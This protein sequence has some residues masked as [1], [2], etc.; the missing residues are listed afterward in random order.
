MNKKL[1]IQVLLP[2]A[3]FYSFKEWQH[4]PSTNILAELLAKEG[5]TTTEVDSTD[6][7]IKHIFPQINFEQLKEQSKK[8][9]RR[10]E[11]KEKLTIDELNSYCKEKIFLELVH[12]HK[13]TFLTSTNAIN[14]QNTL[15][16]KK[17]L[18]QNIIRQFTTTKNKSLED[19]D[20]WNQKRDYFQ[21][22]I[23]AKAYEKL[24]DE[25][26]IS[27][28]I[29]VMSI[30]SV[31]HLHSG[32]VLSAQIKKRKPNTHIVFGG[33]FVNLTEEKKLEQLCKKNILNSYSKK[34]SEHNL[35]L[36]INELAKGKNIQGKIELA[37]E[38]ISINQLTT[39]KRVFQGP[40]RI[41]L[42]KGCYWGK[43]TFCD[44]AATNPYFE[45]KKKEVIIK[46]IKTLYDKGQKE[47]L[48]ITDALPAQY[49]KQ[50][51]EEL[52][53]HQLKIVWGARFLRVEKEYNQELFILMKK[54][55]FAF[56]KYL[57]NIGIDSFSKKALQLAN[58][59]YTPETIS[60]FLEEAKQA[61]ITFERLNIIYDLPGTTFSDMQNTIRL[62]EKYSKQYKTIAFFSLWIST[63]SIM[64]QKPELFGLQLTTTRQGKKVKSVGNL[65]EF[66]DLKGMNAQEKKNIHTQI[67]FFEEINNIC[68]SYPH[69]NKE[70]LLRAKRYQALQKDIKLQ[71]QPNKLTF[72]T[73]FNAKGKRLLKPQECITQD[74]STC[75]DHTILEAQSILQQLEQEKEYSLKELLNTT[76]Q[77]NKKEQVIYEEH[78][79]RT[80]KK[81]L[82][83]EYFL[84]AKN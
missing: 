20:F 2:F 80:I 45:I 7:F 74:I 21:E 1:S 35:L 75:Y 77:Q 39:T 51:A 26:L 48:L 78:Q 40:S 9:I 56:D 29:I 67:K 24:I 65:L 63:T 73:S 41:L 54:S 30:P 8:Q 16:T 83:K 57:L 17:K 58:K 50:I 12:H 79:F 46:E 61:N 52:I 49:A 28:D 69:I 10:L 59:N 31:L 70:N 27:A 84:T 33:A 64:G 18:Y 37:E 38:N 44:F 4:H 71:I 42:S 81:L 15:L 62:L 5:H 11:E 76:T 55:G 23:L 47:F 14:E 66:I 22:G 60:H 3:D 53:K 25:K 82:A 36:L 68:T 6:L 72:L 19:D 43:C 13:Q 34:Y 32:L